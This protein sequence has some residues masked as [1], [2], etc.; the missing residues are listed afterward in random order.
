MRIEKI[1]DKDSIPYHL[2]LLADETTDAIDKYIH[3][4][5]IYTIK[6]N[7]GESIGVYVLRQVNKDTAEIKNIAV[8]EAFQN[9]GIGRLLID[10][11]IARAREAGYR[12]IIV[13]TADT[14]TRQ[15][16]FYE[17]NGFEVFDIKKDFFISNYPQPI[18][19]HGI[20]LKDMI[21]LRKQI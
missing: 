14:G 3:D 7:G 16:R 10:D 17:K 8:A 5:G 1:S 6:A 9:R 20:Q 19:E 21:M 18:Y 4:S 13:G 11:A 2:L 12:E 15:L